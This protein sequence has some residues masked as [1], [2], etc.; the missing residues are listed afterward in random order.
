MNSHSGIGSI[1]RTV[2]I[3]IYK[4]YCTVELCIVKSD[5]TCVVNFTKGAGGY[6]TVNKANLVLARCTLKNL[7]LAVIHCFVFLLDSWVSTKKT[8]C[9]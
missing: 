5:V 4:W 3:M 1:E 9:F 6:L 2:I 8:I 7:F